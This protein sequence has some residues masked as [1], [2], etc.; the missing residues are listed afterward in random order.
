MRPA[1]ASCTGAGSPEAAVVPL[2]SVAA[3][4]KFG[5]KTERDGVDK[6]RLPS[7]RPFIGEKTEDRASGTANRGFNSNNGELLKASTVGMK[8]SIGFML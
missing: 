4:C 6:P 5:E 7:A 3:I 1:S 2:E 8:S